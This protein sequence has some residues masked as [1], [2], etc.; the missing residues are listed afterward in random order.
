MK[1]EELEQLKKKLIDMK[2]AILNGGYLTQNEDLHVSSEDLPDE[3]DLATNVINQQITFEMR[4]R[5][6]NKL[7][8]IDEALKRMEDGTYT[9]CE[10]CGEPIGFKRLSNQPFTNL[11]ITH[12]EENERE[13]NRF[14][15]I[16]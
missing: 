6:L 1:K 5:E 7:R 8:A 16:S 3:A 11:C 2:E 4:Q 15:K 13:K 9:E 10:E 12:A 14:L